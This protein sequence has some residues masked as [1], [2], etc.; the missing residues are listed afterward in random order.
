M[1]NKIVRAKVHMLP[2]KDKSEVVLHESGKLG[3]LPRLSL[4]MDWEFVEKDWTN[5]HLYF[6]TDEEIKEGDWVVCLD[7]IDSTVQNWSVSQ[8]IFKY[9]NGG[10]CNSDMKIVATTDTSL[11][12]KGCLDN[13]N[14]Q[15]YFYDCN[16]I[17][18]PPQTFL[19]NYIEAGGSIDEVDLEYEVIDKGFINALKGNHNYDYKLKVDP[20]HNTVTIHSIKD[21]WSKE[22]MIEKFKSF[23]NSKDVLYMFEEYYGGDI[24]EPLDNWIKENL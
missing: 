23:I 6:T 16:C 14:E 10:N 15:K 7:E 22:E 3:Y 17:P 1:E 21:S 5:Q 24:Y 8:A 2:S 9:N 20:I 19:K 13:K 12:C 18:H 11:Q 4:N